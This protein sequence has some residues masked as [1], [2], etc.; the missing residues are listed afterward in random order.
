MPVRGDRQRPLR[1]QSRASLLC[2]RAS[3]EPL[4]KPVRTSLEIHSY[5]ASRM[6]RCRKQYVR[7]PGS[8]AR[9]ESGPY[10]KRSSESTT[11]GA[12]ADE[13]ASDRSF[14]EDLA[15]DEARRSPL[16]R[17]CLARSSRA[18]TRPGSSRAPVPSRYLPQRPKATLADEQAV[19]DRR[20]G[21]LFD[22]ERVAFGGLHDSCAHSSTHSPAG[23]ILDQ[24]R[25]SSSEGL[26][27][28][29]TLS[30]PPPQERRT[31][32]SSAGPGRRAGSVLRAPSRRGARRG[33]G[34]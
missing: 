5:A 18:A 4:V 25:R 26:E 20:R 10:N 13:E 19:V 1:T 6:S 12:S 23:R 3:G 8:P 34:T 11:V 14:L 17:F 7:P 30:L 32:R 29:I 15:Y 16:V 2:V 9:V 33:Q 31:L 28:R 27:R 21:H 24:L 22:E